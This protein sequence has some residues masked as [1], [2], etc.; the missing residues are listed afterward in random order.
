MHRLRILC[1]SA[2]LA[3]G[4]CSWSDPGG[5]EVLGAVVDDRV[6]APP[7]DEALQLPIATALDSAAFR[8]KAP[9][10]RPRR[11]RPKLSPLADTISRALVFAPT[12]QRWFT[13]AGRGKRLLID[14]GRVDA[15]A[16]ST[17]ERIAAYVEAVDSLSPIRPG[18]RFRLFGHWGADDATVTGFDWWEG[19]IVATVETTPRVD[20]IVRRVSPLTVAAVRAD[21]AIDAATSSC[22]RGAVA[23]SV[24]LRATSVRDSVA[25]AMIDSAAPPYERLART[26][27]LRTSRIAGCF[28]TGRVM[29][30]ISLRGGD[31]EWVR[32]RFLLIDEAGAIHRLRVSDYRFD[33]HDGVAALDADGDGIDDLVVRGRAPRAGGLVILRLSEG[34][35][36]ERLTSGFAWERS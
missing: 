4:A 7:A 33:A 25:Q 8:I 20:S 11:R 29:L 9:P 3:L 35:R 31:S 2:L 27:Q 23:D 30:I 14:I 16:R 15:D 32:E 17:P 19:R 34:K 28:G 13:A 10:P 5:Q 22:K 18:T 36:L 26:L 21:S 1:T 6:L 12:E 24:M